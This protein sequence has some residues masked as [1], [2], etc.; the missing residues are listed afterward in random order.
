MTERIVTVP[1]EQRAEIDAVR[2]GEHPG[3]VIVERT[4]IVVQEAARRLGVSV[5][6][7]QALPGYDALTDTVPWESSRPAPLRPSRGSGQAF[8]II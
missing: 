3:Q 5:A 8:G 6:E 2:R 7:V 4:R 1:P